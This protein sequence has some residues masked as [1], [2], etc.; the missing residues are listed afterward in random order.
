MSIG[1]RML[2]DAPWQGTGAGT[3]AAITPIY[4]DGAIEAIAATAPTAAAA[5]TVELGSPLCWLI[6]AANVAAIVFLFRAAL[7]RG[8]DSF[9]AAAGAGALVALLFLFF[10]NAGSLGSA[11]ATIAAALTGLAFA[12]SKSRTAR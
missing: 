11:A 3:Y 2:A 6:V 12:Q 10:I 1:E 8:R 4:G 9:Y 5:A 7:R